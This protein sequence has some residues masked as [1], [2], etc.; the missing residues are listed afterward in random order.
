MPKSKSENIAY[1]TWWGN[2]GSMDD[3]NFA[4]E[5]FVPEIGKLITRVHSELEKIIVRDAYEKAKAA[6]KFNRI[7]LS[8]KI[9]PEVEF[10]VVKM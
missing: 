5:Q 8:V 9:T 6:G 3:E 7:T 2:I 1:T 10:G 4:D